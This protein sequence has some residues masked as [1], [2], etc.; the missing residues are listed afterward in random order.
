TGTL[1]RLSLRMEGGSR[2]EAVGAN[3][4][5]GGLIGDN[6]AAVTPE[7]VSFTLVDGSVGSGAENAV[8]GGMIG[9]Q[10]GDVIGMEWD[11]SANFRISSTGAGDTLGGMIGQH[12]S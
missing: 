8:I 1:A 11:M 10:A 7:T 2:I 9:K 4:V 3:S 12:I 6:S 5:A